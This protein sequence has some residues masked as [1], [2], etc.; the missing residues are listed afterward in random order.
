M[1]FVIVCSVFSARSV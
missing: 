1:A